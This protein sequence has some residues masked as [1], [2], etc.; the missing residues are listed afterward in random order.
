MATAQNVPVSEILRNK[1]QLEEDE[2]KKKSRED[3]RK[4]KE[5]EEARKVLEFH[6]IT[7]KNTAGEG[8]LRRWIDDMKRKDSG[9]VSC[10]NWRWCG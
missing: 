6:C 10:K 7:Y 4:A 2:P 8:P 3:W 1:S 9:E 5:L